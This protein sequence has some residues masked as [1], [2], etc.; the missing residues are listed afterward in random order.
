MADDLKAAGIAVRAAD[1]GRVLMIQRSTHDPKDKAAGTWEFPGGKMEDGEHPYTAAKREWQEE[2]G[3][4]LPR[5]K[6]VGSWQSGVYQG[7]VHE[8]PSEASI[9]TNLNPEDRRVMNPDDPDGDNVEVAAWWQP[10]HLRHMHALRPELRVSRPWQK[11]QKSQAHPANLRLRVG[12]IHSHSDGMRSYGMVSREGSYV[13]RTQP[14]KVRA[15]KGDTLRLDAAHFSLDPQGDPYWL[16]PIVSGQSPDAPHSWRQLTALAGASHVEN[17]PTV[18]EPGPGDDDTGAYEEDTNNS[19]SADG[20]AGQIPAP[21]DEYNA[22]ARIDQSFEGVEYDDVQSGRQARP[23]PEEPE[24]RRR[25]IDKDGPT[26]SQVHVNAPLPN[27]SVSYAATA[28]RNKLLTLDPETTLSV[29]K[30]DRMKQVVYGVVL[31]P[32]VL[33]SQQDFMRPQEIEKTAHGYL[34]KVAK[35]K[36]SVTKLQ[37]RAQAFFKSKPSLVPVESFIAPCDFSYD[38]VEQ[39]K[40]GTWVL[41][42]HVEDPAVWDDVLKGKY[43]GFSIGGSGLRQEMSLPADVLSEDGYQWLGRTAPSDFAPPVPYLG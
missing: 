23:G 22:Q 27:I 3:T 32:N 26:L 13:G 5:G 41:A 12:R 8:V 35:G 17:A 14:T 7:F 36:A 21:G 4:R 30:A 11:V 9:K 42:L 10:Q 2:M 24:G 15:T 43:T 31:E 6:H 29:K 39:V 18:S 1:T 20:P 16:S 38:G 37:H 28:K 34:G 19:Y 25:D 40:K 33:D